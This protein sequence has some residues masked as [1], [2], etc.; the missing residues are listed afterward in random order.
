MNI[1]FTEYLK[2]NLESEQWLC[3]KCEHVIGSAREP[4]KQGLKLYQRDPQEIH[5]PILDPA[6]YRYTFAPSATLCSIIECYC[7]GCGALV[8]TE[9]VPTGLAPTVDIEF[10]FDELKAHWQDIGD[11]PEPGV[12]PDLPKRECHHH[13]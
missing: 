6:I 1:Y 5:K 13:H 7:P 4:Y 10:D 11:V 8:E 9:Y 12:G 3:R 2:V